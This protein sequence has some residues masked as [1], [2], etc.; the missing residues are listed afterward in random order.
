MPERTDPEKL[1]PRVPGLDFEKRLAD[2]R[3]LVLLRYGS[4]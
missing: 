2:S 3:K 4:E 1:H